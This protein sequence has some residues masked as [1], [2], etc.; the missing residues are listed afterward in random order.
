MCIICEKGKNLAT[1]QQVLISLER[2][3]CDDLE[4]YQFVQ[5]KFKELKV[6][7]DETEERMKEFISI[8]EKYLGI[9]PVS[10]YPNI[11]N[12]EQALKN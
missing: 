5:K 2:D 8:T 9:Q 3:N 10:F 12:E 7:M 4:V 11:D 6:E 1:L